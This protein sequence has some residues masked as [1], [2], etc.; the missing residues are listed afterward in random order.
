MGSKDAINVIESYTTGILEVDIPELLHPI[1][2]EARTAKLQQI[3]PSQPIEQ[4]PIDYANS[5]G[6]HPVLHQETKSLQ[7]TYTDN[8]SDE[9]RQLEQLFINTSDDGIPS[10]NSGCSSLQR[11]LHHHPDILSSPEKPQYPARAEQSTSMNN[12]DRTDAKTS[13]SVATTVGPVLAQYYIA[14]VCADICSK[15]RQCFDG[16]LWSTLSRALP[17]LIEAFAIKIGHSSSN[18]VNRQIMYFIHKRHN[19]VLTQLKTM[20]QCGYDG[21]L[22]SSRAKRENMSLNDKMIMWNRKSGDDRPTDGLYQKVTDDKDEIT[23]RTD[24]PAYHKIIFD[25]PAYEWLLASLRNEVILQWSLKQPHVMVKGIRQRILDQLPTGT[26]GKQRALFGH[27]VK[28]DLQWGDKSKGWFQHESNDRFIRSDQPFAE[29]IVVTGSVQEAQALT[30]KQYLCQTWPKGGPQLL[31]VLQNVINGR[32]RYYSVRL[33]DN[34]QL[35]AEIGDSHLIITATGPAQFISECGEQLAW[36]KAALSNGILHHSSYCTPSIT[37]YWVSPSLSESLEYE[38]YFKIGSDIAHSVHH[39]MKTDWLFDMPNS[40]KAINSQNLVLK[41]TNPVNHSC[42]SQSPGARNDAAV[43]SP[44]TTGIADYSISQDGEHRF[45]KDYPQIDS[46]LSDA[47]LLGAQSQP[48]VAAGSP[49]DSLESDLLSMSDTSEQIEPLDSNTPEYLLLYPLLQKLLLGF[50][51]TTQCQPS[52]GEN[53]ETSATQPATT[54]STNATCNAIQYQKRN[55]GQEYNDDIS[56]SGSRKR[57]RKKP[58]PSQSETLQRTLACPYLKSDPITHHVKQHLNREH[59]PE[60]YCQRCFRTDFRTEQ[61]HQNH[62]NLSACPI[63]DPTILNGLSPQQQRQLSRKSN[64]SFSEEEQ[65]FAMWIILFP[66]V[67]RPLSPYMDNGISEDMRLFREYCLTRGPAALEMQLESNT[68]WNS[69]IITAEQRQVHLRRVIAQG[70]DSLFTEFLLAVPSLEP[71]GDKKTSSSQ[72]ENHNLHPIQLE[73]PTNSN[74]DSGVA[75]E[76]QVSDDATISL[77]GLL[78]HPSSAVEFD[79]QLAAADDQVQYI[80]AMQELTQ[81]PIQDQGQNSLDPALGHYFN[82]QFFSTEWP[83][84]QH[85]SQNS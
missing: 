4:S 2:T 22:N 57:P 24:L 31:G 17:M 78:D 66:G 14:E 9:P 30:I 15:L 67:Q 65:W 64:P 16:K 12:F 73:T 29:F 32:D 61:D 85:D 80:L 68:T 52:P 21:L 37:S 47:D 71:M 20:L 55:R 6:G 58:N 46:L 70:I 35:H 74:A 62:V 56:E 39:D 33:P 10:T 60:Y 25:S 82:N 44:S 8:E 72:P 45:Q 51:S 19:Q 84:P 49:I 50:R 41:E 63:E 43:L 79:Y 42:L 23:N 34:T 48:N 26:V 7:S 28:F 1:Y 18:Q 69:A 75:L 13:H 53:R 11:N 27:K 76:S 36:L 40:T 3:P 5:N 38:G 77:R 59:V 54:T 83:V 81:E